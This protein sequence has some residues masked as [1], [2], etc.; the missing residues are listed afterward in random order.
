MVIQQTERELKGERV[1]RRLNLILS[2]RGG[3]ID[4][5]DLA[6]RGGF[7][8]ATFWFVSPTNRRGPS[9]VALA[10]WNHSSTSDRR[11]RRPVQAGLPLLDGSFGGGD[12][13]AIVKRGS[14]TFG[15]WQRYRASKLF[16][17]PVAD[18]A[19]ERQ[20]VGRTT[21]GLARPRNNR[22]FL[23]THED[24]RSSRKR[25]RHG[26]FTDRAHVGGLQRRCCLF[27]A[28]FRRLHGSPHRPGMLLKQFDRRFSSCEDDGRFRVSSCSWP[29][30]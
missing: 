3:E 29:P 15:D 23:G 5:I 28:A 27:G 12:P 22:V 8:P 30:R 24:V 25:C 9:P 14:R 2:W 18:R 1:I 11:C 26:H 20:A 17:H 19:A 6:Q 7:E 13:H 16:Y 4:A 21:S 10:D